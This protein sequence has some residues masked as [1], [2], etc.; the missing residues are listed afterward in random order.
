MIYYLISLLVVGITLTT[1]G[2]VMVVRAKKMKMDL[3]EEADQELV[4]EAL[5]NTKEN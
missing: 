5:E 2:M 3:M 4:D 1:L